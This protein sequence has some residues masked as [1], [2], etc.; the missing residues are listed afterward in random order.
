MGDFLH[1]LSP[2]A[3]PPH[4]NNKTK[5][6]NK[7]EYWK[8]KKKNC[9]W[10][11]HFTH[12][13]KNYYMMYGSWDTKWDTEWDRHN[14]LSFWVIF[15]LLP[16]YQPEKITILQS[17]KNPWR[18]MAIIWC[19]VSEIW[20]VTD[21]SLSFYARGY[22]FLHLCTTNDDHIR[23]GYWDM[24]C[25]RQNLLSFWA[26]F[27]PFTLLTTWKI[28]STKKEKK[29]LGDIIILHL[30]TTNDDHMMYDSWDMEHDRHFFLILDHFLPFYP[31]KMWKNLET[32]SF[33]TFVP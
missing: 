19:M 24:K 28:K 29:T 10:Y 12:V 17:E 1:F 5:Q 9:W 8:N 2:W 6:T 4:K 18:Y 3:P 22:R 13:P 11:N 31:L 21:K 14:F 23:H 33:N 32:P 7:T 15:A 30:C 20:R 16:L 26:I 25:D 27:C